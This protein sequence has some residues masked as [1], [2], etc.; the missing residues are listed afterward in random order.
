[1]ARNV[2]LAAIQPGSPLYIDPFRGK[3][4]NRRKILPLAEK[5]VQNI[6]RLL[7]QAGREGTDLVC[8]TEDVTG[9]YCYSSYPDDGKLFLS[10]AESIPG[11][12]SDKLSRIAKRYGMYIVA[13][14]DEVCEGKYYN[15]S[16]L[17][18]RKGKVAGKYHKVHLAPDEAHYFQAGDEF[19]VFKTDLG[20]LGLMTCFDNWFPEV[21]RILALR[22]ADVL[23]HCTYGVCMPGETDQLLKARARAVDNTVYLIMSAYGNRI[24]SSHPGRSCVIDTA[25]NV[26]ADAGY[27]ADQVV[28]AVVDMDYERTDEWDEE[29]TGIKQVRPR[30][31]VNRKPHLYGTIVEERPPLFDRYQRLE[32][33]PRKALQ[34][35]YRKLRDERLKQKA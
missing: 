15:T 22:G 9:T 29:R 4:V 27:R 35:Y 28:T 14:M 5:N 23:V 30:L 8:A 19:P 1:M 11:P 21:A 32:I 2:K 12:I 31:L 16:F 26:M 7:E 20:N 3:G 25:G 18:D 33:R 34:E 24:E 13:N 6:C 10:F 17:I